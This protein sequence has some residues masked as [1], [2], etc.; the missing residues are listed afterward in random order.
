[1]FKGIE[2]L[3]EE[4]HDVEKF[5]K[6][7]Y[8]TLKK[9]TLS[10]LKPYFPEAWH[11]FQEV[12]NS[13]DYRSKFYQFEKLWPIFFYLFLKLQGE[14]MSMNKYL[15]I[16]CLNKDEFKE[17]LRK[18]K[19]ISKV[20]QK[21][22]RKIIVYKKLENLQK[23]FRLDNNILE[24]TID[25]LNAFWSII[26]ESTDDIIT[27]TVFSLGL[28]YLDEKSV[29]FNRVCKELGI[30]QGNMI[31][32]IKNKIFTNLGVSGFKSMSESKELIKKVIK[33]KIENSRAINLKN[34]LNTMHKE[35]EEAIYIIEYERD[36]L[37]KATD[38]NMI[39]D[40]KEEIAVFQ[41]IL[42]N[43]APRD[44]TPLLKKLQ[45]MSRSEINKIEI[46]LKEQDNTSYELFKSVREIYNF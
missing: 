23:T 32:Q 44:F 17:G 5:S 30:Q 33:R 15:D 37:K 34:F 27:G 29:T 18:S 1:M 26:R 40:C 38:K 19:K 31:Y 14:N 6:I 21:R 39:K 43:L 42:K 45:T 25:I 22:D 28:M 46:K 41:T 4:R 12:K 35:I 9:L 36:Q 10:R 7:F 11:L 16:F 8:D 3:E 20:Y 24:K 13:L 2:V